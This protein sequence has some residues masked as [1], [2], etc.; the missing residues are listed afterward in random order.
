[1]DAKFFMK[2]ARYCA[3]PRKLCASVAF[4]GGLALMRDATFLS[5]ALIPSLSPVM[6]SLIVN[7][8]HLFPNSRIQ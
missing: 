1:M 5:S 3:K 8:C 7:T 6:E 4:F 2:R